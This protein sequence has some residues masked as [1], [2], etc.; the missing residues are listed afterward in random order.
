M[1]RRDVLVYLSALHVVNNWFSL[2]FFWTRDFIAVIKQVCIWSV[3]RYMASVHSIAQYYCDSWFNIII[4]SISTCAKCFTHFG[5]S[6]SN[7]VWT[8]KCFI[9]F[10]FIA[11]VI[12]LNSTSY[13][14]PNIAVFST[15]VISD[16]FCP[17]YIS[18]CSQIFSLV[19]GP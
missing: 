7:F 8:S 14:A 1:C 5:F 3:L 9:L 6:D 10:N 12:A 13:E 11:L 4:P 19:V 17:L 18:L 15:L 2:F 16:F